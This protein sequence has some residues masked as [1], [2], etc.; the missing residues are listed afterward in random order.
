MSIQTQVCVAHLSEVNQKG[1]KYNNSSAS[2]QK[3]KPLRAV[4]HQQR[5]NPRIPDSKLKGGWLPMTSTEAHTHTPK[6]ETGGRINKYLAK[7]VE[8]STQH[9][10]QD[11]I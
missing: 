3:T 11:R 5:N 10:Y 9:S 8:K 2:K 4:R 1:I 7:Y 6:W